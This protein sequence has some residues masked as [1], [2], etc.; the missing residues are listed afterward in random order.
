VGKVLAGNELNKRFN[1]NG[2]FNGAW[3]TKVGKINQVRGTWTYTKSRDYCR[4]L[5]VILGNGDIKERGE[6]C[7]KLNFKANN[8]YRL[9]T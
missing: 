3:A 1:R 5:M 6:A 2:S 4:R 8:K 9:E 7:E